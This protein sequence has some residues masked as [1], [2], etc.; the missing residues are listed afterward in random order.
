MTDEEL[1]GYAFIHCETELALFHRQHIIRLFALAG[2]EC[3]DL[4]FRSFW[5]V[6][7][8]IVKPLVEK[9]V[10]RLQEEVSA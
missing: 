9:A 10:K 7:P 1:L 4:G 5:S 8:E 3:P 6:G 2:E